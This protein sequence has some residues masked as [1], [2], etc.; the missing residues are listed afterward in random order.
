MIATQLERDTYCLRRAGFLTVPNFVPNDVMD[1]IERAAYDWEDEIER[2]KAAG[3]HVPLKHFRPLTTTRCLHAISTDIQNIA[4]APRIQEIA[5]GYLPKP[6]LRDCVVQSNMPDA[7]NAARGVNGPVSYH[8]DALWSGAPSP[9]YLHVFLLLTDF[10]PEN[11][12]TLLVPGSHLVREPGYYFKRTDPRGRVDGIEY[13]VYEKSY[14]GS[15]VHLSAPRGSLIFMD[16][17]SIHTQ[18]ANTTPHKRSMVN[19]TF[20]D[21]AAPGW[22]E[23]LNARQIASR[24][25]RV[26]VR[27]DLLEQLEVD[28]NRP[29][30]YGPLGNPWPATAEATPA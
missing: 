30:T 28:A 14:F 11:G 13:T 29:D 24:Y 22:P 1:R 23:L 8:R 26:P 15:A 16:G 4:M 21:L 12:A 9:M 2:F 6:V 25:S 19:I 10:T 18:G 7:H 17:T 27:P 5:A 20:K 3:A